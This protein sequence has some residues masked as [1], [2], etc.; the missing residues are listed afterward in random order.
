M[1]IPK[2]LKPLSLITCHLSLVVI[3]SACNLLPTSKEPEPVTLEYW[4]L[5][6]TQTAMDTIISDYKKIKPSVNI[7][8]KKRAPQQYRETVENQIQ[9]GKGPDIFTF[10]NTWVPMLKE[11]LEPVPQDIVSQSDFKNNYYP[12]VFADLRADGKFVGV[13]FVHDGLA[14]CYNEDIFKAAGITKAPATWI[15]FAQDAAKLT[16]KDGAGN[17]RTAG[18]A[19]GTAGNVDHFSDILGMMVLQNGGDLASPTDK[20][21]A[22]ALEYFAS[23]AK[24]ENRVWDETMPSSTVAFAGSN[25]AMYL[26]PSWR[27]IDI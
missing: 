25:L 18:A 26:A 2:I 20:K 14:L 13:P 22:D 19:L 15:E 23:F 10:H 16:V 21:T 3:L 11:E 1:T 9:S 4:D 27:A 24:G 8:Y 17:I 6:A 7:S 12:V 5:W